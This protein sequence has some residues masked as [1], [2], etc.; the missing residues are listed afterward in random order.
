MAQSKR[1]PSSASVSAFHPANGSAVTRSH[2]S[3]V[4]NSRSSSISIVA[5]ARANQSRYPSARAASFRSRASSRTSSATS[6][7][8]VFEPSH[9]S[10]RSA[11]SSLSRSRRRIS[12]SSIRRPPTTARCLEKRESTDASSPTIRWRISSGT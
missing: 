4:A 11:T 3:S 5:S 2:S 10:R 1:R 7:P 9:A 6:A 12:L 8:T